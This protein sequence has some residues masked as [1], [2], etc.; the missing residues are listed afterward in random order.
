MLARTLGWPAPHSSFLRV[1]AHMEENTLRLADAVYSSS[2][3]SPE[4]CQRVYGL[5]ME[6]VPVIHAG[7]D[8]TR[9][10]PLEVEGDGRPTIVFAGRLVAHKGV[11]ALV[12]AACR[13]GAAHPDL[14]VKLVGRADRAMVCRLQE[15]AA[16]AGLPALLEFVGFVPREELAVQ[17]CQAHL[18]AAPSEYEGGPGFVYLEAMACGL[19]VIACA[20]SGAAEV[21]QA[22]A[23]GLLVPPRDHDALCAAL[24]RLLA[25]PR[26]RRAMGLRARRYV[27]RHADA[28]ACTARLEAFYESVLAGRQTVPGTP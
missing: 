19:P 25:S 3:C 17:L 23:T 4:W 15:T 28:R 5:D 13:V 24:E 9:F 20:G 22:G 6:R 14:R 11:V 26:R 1:A 12:E 16:Q 18:F 27:E 8:L 7:V 2:R 10:R 21:V